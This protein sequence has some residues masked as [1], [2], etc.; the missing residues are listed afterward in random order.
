M[1]LQRITALLSLTAVAS[2]GTV[3]MDASGGLRV[4]NV[5]SISN[6]GL[7]VVVSSPGTPSALFPTAS[8]EILSL[9]SEN[10]PSLYCRGATLSGTSDKERASLAVCSLV[11]GTIVIDGITVGDV[12]AGLRNSRHARTLT[13]LFR[14]R[15]KLT[16]D[17]SDSDGSDSADSTTSIQQTLLVVLADAESIDEA[18]LASDIKSL[19]KAASVEKKGAGSFSDMY[20]LKIVSATSADQVSIVVGCGVESIEQCTVVGSP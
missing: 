16:D 1:L 4:Q 6:D 20:N 3:L 11:A 12:E 19:Y 18:E 10:P 5:P 8:E 15:V 17:E 13:A 14:A 7:V 9:E 2:A